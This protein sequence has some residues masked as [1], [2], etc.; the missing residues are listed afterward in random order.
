MLFKQSAILIFAKA[1]LEGQVKTRLIP[2]LGAEGA[3]G[4]YRR[5]L[6]NL[7]NSLVEERLA[8]IE[9]W[10]AP[11]A[12]HP[13]FQKMQQLPRLTLHEQLGGDLGERM[14]NAVIDARQRHRHL[15]LLGVDCPA[16]TVAM[17]QQVFS[18]LADDVDA[19]LGPAEDG[20]Y[21]LLG[22]NRTT[23]C[24]FQGIPWGSGA[25]AEMTRQCMRKLEWSWRELPELWDLDRPEDLLR[26]AANEKVM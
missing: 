10:C 1:P 23:E 12:A 19:V 8:A 18:W 2:A 9:L 11:D 3:T 20:G 14:A 17:L 5:L 13:D 25:V 6:A 21:V 15:V 16:L 26:M 7:V 4:L 24:L 22:L